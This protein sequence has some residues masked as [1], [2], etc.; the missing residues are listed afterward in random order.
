MTTILSLTLFEA[1]YIFGT[2]Q[3]KQSADKN[4]VLGL[5]RSQLK[6]RKKNEQFRFIALVS[7]WYQSKPTAYLSKLNK[8][9]SLLCFKKY[10][11]SRIFKILFQSKH[12]SR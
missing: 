3:N 6:E 12:S 1:K 5:V 11:T 10:A 7:E 4:N 2:Y 9:P 8:I